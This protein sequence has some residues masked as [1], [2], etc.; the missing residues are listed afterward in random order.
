M[1]NSIMTWL[2]MAGTFLAANIL[3]ALLIVIVGIILIRVVMKLIGK[4]LE[5]AKLDKIASNL[6][7]TVIR[8]VLYVLLALMVADKIGIDVTGVVA[9]ASVLTLAV[10]LS[11]QNALTNVIG[12]FT[13]LY[14]KPFVAGDFVEVAGQS[15]TVQSIGLAY[16]CLTTGDNKKVSIPNS[17]VVSAEIVNYT[18][19]GTR[20]V[21]IT[22][23][24]SY[25]A[26]VDG[27]LEALRE[28]GKLPTALETPAP[29]AAVKNYGDS[30]IEY[31]LQVWC[32][33]EDYWTTLFEGNKRVKEVFDEKGIAMTYPHINVHL[34]K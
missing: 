16:T 11:V 19:T 1:I 10:S 25:E 34:D 2:T 22:V 9:L 26:A 31:V 15:G 3:P 30:A 21:D 20:R 29:F 18:A 14:T 6:I 4:L 32:K 12:G 7:K 23:S 5:K 8:V 24:A 28:A 17:S 33:S 27:V 13:L